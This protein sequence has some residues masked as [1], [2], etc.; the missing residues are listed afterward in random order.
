MP[1]EDVRGA[2]ARREIALWVPARYHNM[3]KRSTLKLVIHRET[4][5]VLA[6]LDLGRVAGGGPDPQLMDTG[7]GANNTCVQ[8][9]AV[10]QALPAKP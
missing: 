6:R 1:R 2:D 4:V 8:A 9:A 5:K 10:A 7:G 3:M